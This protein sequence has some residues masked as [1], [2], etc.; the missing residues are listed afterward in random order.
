MGNNL[1]T[2]FHYEQYLLNYPDLVL[3]DINTYEKALN[4]WTTHGI[5]ENRTCS[6]LK[7]DWEQYLLN[8][9]DLVA[10][11]IDNQEKALY[12]WTTYGI[13]EKR[14]DKYYVSLGSNCSIAIMLGK[15]YKNFFN[16]KSTNLFDFMITKK[17]P[18]SQVD[19]IDTVIL[20]LKNINEV[21]KENYKFNINDLTICKDEKWLNYLKNTLIG[22][23]VHQTVFHPHFISIHDQ[24]VEHDDLTELNNKL[25]RRLERL[26][27]IIKTNKTI[28]FIRYEMDIFDLNDYI[29]FKNIINRINP[30]LNIKIYIISNSN[31]NPTHTL[32]YLKICTL[33]EFKNKNPS[34]ELW[35]EF[36]WELFFKLN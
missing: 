34:N 22:G 8:Y 31:Y 24:P 4:H 35:S 27:N 26:I 11:G 3:A 18:H 14:I 15:I 17:Y 30:E 12:H 19:G 28:N 5:H 23:I 36:N 6:P 20:S 32:E 25:N 21:L 10:A 16:N 9:P 2:S 33:S 29:D 7:F 1:S 13:H